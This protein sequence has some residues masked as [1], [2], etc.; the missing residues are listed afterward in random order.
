MRIVLFSII[1][2]FIIF[3][4][5]NAQKISPQGYFLQ[6]SMAIGEH[7][8]YSLSV[9]YPT[10]LQ[11][12]FPDSTYNFAPFEYVEKQYFSTKSDSI[13]SRDSVVYTLASFEIEPLQTLKLPIFII[14]GGDSLSVEAALDSLG[15]QEQI[16]VVSDSLQLKTD[17]EFSKLKRQ[18]NYPYLLFFLGVLGIITLLVIILFGKKIIKKW[19]IYRLQKRHQKFI[20]VFSVQIKAV[21]SLSVHEIEQLVTQ[22]KKHAEI[23]GKQPF[24]KLTSKEIHAIRKEEALYNNLKLIDKTI[25]SSKGKED[26]SQ[27]FQFLLNYAVILL[28]ERINAI[29]ADGQ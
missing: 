4:D 26:A 3:K 29:E 24:A 6:D 11:I 5:L 8:K 15:L 13:F 16:L 20:E 27:A 21:K 28:E 17:T 10:H 7:V 1:I 2:C 18:F 19:K 14:Q 12:L 22:W 23:V 9:R 25:Y